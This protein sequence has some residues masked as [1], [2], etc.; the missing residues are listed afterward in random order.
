MSLI[1]H[2]VANPGQGLGML[3]HPSD[4]GAPP[5]FPKR[6][7]TMMLGSV[8]PS[9][10]PRGRFMATKE[11]SPSLCTQ[12]IE[13]ARADY[14]RKRVSSRGP[15]EPV[16]G[17]VAKTLYPA[18]HK[19]L[20]LS[21]TTCD[22]WKAQPSKEGFRTSRR[23][24]PLAPRYPLPSSKER[25]VTPP[26][27]LV[28]EGRVRETME[29]KGEHKPRIVEKSFSRDPN[30]I[31]DI[32]FVRPN[33]RSYMRP[34]APRDPMKVVEQAGDRMLSARNPR[35]TRVS[36][37]LNPEYA[38]PIVT[39]H[40]LLRNE[41]ESAR[42]PRDHG[43][44]EGAAPRVLHRAR[45]RDGHG[46]DEMPPAG[47]R[48]ARG[49]SCGVSQRFKG[50]LPFNMYDAPEVTRVAGGTGLDCSDIDGAQTGTRKL[51]TWEPL[52]KRR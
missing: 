33:V 46:G 48:S 25:P 29:F 18:L 52:G 34:I 22:I 2:G 49:E 39:T 37:P 11:I 27:V 16:P 12:D 30:D 45:I 32:D 8:G 28:H 14:L 24:D 7:E 5:P 31:S 3:S 1:S 6:S 23:L 21:L 36:D 26:G 40:P 41:P 51:G 13:G 50:I 15:P 19:P 35:S 47:A 38:V 42:A 44:V 9:D 10:A 20:D 43:A 4:S 17:A